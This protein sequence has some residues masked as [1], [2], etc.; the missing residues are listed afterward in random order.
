MASHNHDDSCISVSDAN[1]ILRMD[2][3]FRC[4]RVAMFRCSSLGSHS[5][6]TKTA[7]A[8]PFGSMPPLWVRSARFER[9]LSGMRSA[10]ASAASSIARLR[11]NQWDEIRMTR[12]LCLDPPITCHPE[13]SDE[14]SEGSRA[15]ETAGTSTRFCLPRFLHYPLRGFPPLGMISTVEVQDRA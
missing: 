9:S 4:S 10:K 7:P 1:G 3:E 2:R 14:R 5:R 11:V 12:M 6:E 8:P 13:R 15:R